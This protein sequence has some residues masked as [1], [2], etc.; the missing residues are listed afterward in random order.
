[1]TRALLIIDVQ[2]AIVEMSPPEQT[3]T[4]LGEARPFQSVTLYAKVSGYLKDVQVDKGDTVEQGQLLARIESP[5]TN[6]QYEAAQADASRA[7]ARLTGSGG[8]SM[9][10]LFKAMGFSHPKLGPLPGFEA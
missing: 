4:L 9:G 10:Q 8:R 2:V 1:M 7:L 6:Q 5:E 3:L